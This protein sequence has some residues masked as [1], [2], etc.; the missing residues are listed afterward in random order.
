MAP[1]IRTVCRGQGWGRTL[2]VSGALRREGSDLLVASK[3]G[4]KWHTGMLAGR[5][6]IS[7]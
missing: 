3:G 6:S 7:L 4:E 2:G 5:F 1:F